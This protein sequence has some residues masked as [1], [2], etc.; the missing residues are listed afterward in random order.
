VGRTA[1]AAGSILLGHN[2]AAMK[3]MLVLAIKDPIQAAMMMEKAGLPK[4]QIAQ[5]LSQAG[6]LL[7][8]GATVG[9]EGLLSGK[10]VTASP[11]LL[12]Q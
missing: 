1:K 3:D 11:S 9:A 12:E 6:G 7:G 5:I 2:D 10:S 8:R 4:S